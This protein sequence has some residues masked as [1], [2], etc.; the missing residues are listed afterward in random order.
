MVRNFSILIAL[1]YMNPSF[2]RFME[3]LR[4]GKIMFDIRIGSYKS[5]TKRGKLHDHGSGF[6]IL[7]GDIRLL[8]DIHEVVE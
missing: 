3:L 8:Y 4:A 2:N 6:R 5:G 7:G 1:I